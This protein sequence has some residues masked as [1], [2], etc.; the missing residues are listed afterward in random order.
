MP[1]FRSNSVVTVNWRM[2]SST[3]KAF[4]PSC[5]TGGEEGVSVGWDSCAVAFI[6]GNLTVKVLPSP[7][8]LSRVNS[9]SSKWTSCNVIVKPRPVPSA[10]LLCCGVRRVNSL[11]ISSCS[12]SVIPGPESLITMINW[13]S[14]VGEIK[15]DKETF[16]SR[17]YFMAFDRIFTT[18]WRTFME[19]PR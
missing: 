2:S 17:V 12:S 8:L 3:I 7:F 16:P 19:S 4:I 14:F 5:L 9:P 10:P 6:N 13:S 1:A 18:I 11:N 15:A